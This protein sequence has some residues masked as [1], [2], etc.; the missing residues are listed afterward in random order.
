MDDIYVIVTTL[1]RRRHF[2]ETI[3]VVSETVIV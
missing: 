2:S 3:L 1:H